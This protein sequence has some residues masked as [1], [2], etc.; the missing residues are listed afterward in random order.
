MAYS[1]RLIQAGIVQGRADFR[2]RLVH[3]RSPHAARNSRVHPLVCDFRCRRS[4]WGVPTSGAGRI[5]RL[6]WT[7][8]LKPKRESGLDCFTCATFARQR[9]C[10]LRKPKHQ[11]RNPRKWQWLQRERQWL[12]RC[13]VFRGGDPLRRGNWSRFGHWRRWPSECLPPEPRNL[14]DVGFRPIQVTVLAPQ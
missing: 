10:I 11:P 13:W 7:F 12:Q 4:R 8:T 2:R 14:R 5:K 3:A 1:A 9:L 6:K